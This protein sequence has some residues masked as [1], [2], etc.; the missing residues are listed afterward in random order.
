MA[1]HLLVWIIA[2]AATAG[3][4]LRPWNL[5]EAIWAVSGALLLVVLGLLPASA[6][7]PRVSQ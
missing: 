4:I 2:A 1:S 5:P 7:G 6:G 3:V